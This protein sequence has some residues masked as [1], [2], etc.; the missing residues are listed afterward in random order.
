MGRPPPR[1]SSAPRLILASA[2]PRRRELLARLGLPFAVR[3]PA[4]DESPRPGEAPEALAR[5]LALAKAL[6]VAREEPGAV[7][8]GADTLV[9]V[10]GEVLGKPA[11]REE[12]LAMLGRLSGRAHEVLTAVAAA[13]PGE[14]PP[15]VLLQRSRVRFRPLRPGE[16]AWYWETGE[17]ADKAGAY[18]V[19]GIG[20][21]FIRRLEG[22]PSAV[23]GLPLCETAELLAARGLAPWAAGEGSGGGGP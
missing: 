11:G 4:V 2:S 21:M 5:R 20:A 12:A 3:V 15:Q 8:L 9:V 14:R 17:P 22:S 1:A 7:V 23:M 13:G 6:A 19:Q 16:A 18:A 10:E